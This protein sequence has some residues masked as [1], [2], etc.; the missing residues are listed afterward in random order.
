M[1]SKLHDEA[2]A[3]LYRD[4]PALALDV[5]NRI[6]ED[7][8]QAEGDR[9]PIAVALPIAELAGCEARTVLR[10]PGDAERGEGEQRDDPRDVAGIDAGGAAVLERGI[11]AG[12]NVLSRGI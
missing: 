3:D 2:M 8:N 6:F 9:R 12:Q 7:G 1:R 10:Q 11:G 4:D 5:I